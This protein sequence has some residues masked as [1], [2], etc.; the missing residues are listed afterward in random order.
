[1]KMGDLK[2]STHYVMIIQEHLEQISDSIEASII[3]P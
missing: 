3:I 1:M 2:F